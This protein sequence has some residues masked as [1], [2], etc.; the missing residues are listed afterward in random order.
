MTARTLI[1]A[2]ALTFFTF[3][4][5][6]AQEQEEPPAKQNAQIEVIL[7]MASNSGEGVDPKLE[8]YAETLERL[9][10]FSTYQQ[11]DRKVLSVNIPGGTTTNLFGGTK[12]K[13]GL[14][15]LE[16]DKLP[17]N[18]DWRRGDQKLLRTMIKLNDGTPAV[19]GGPQ[20]ED[21]TGTY[22]L[23]VKWRQ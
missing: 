3:I 6:H 10:R 13:L 5:A 18:L 4:C 11:K 1:L 15:P 16:D 21:N 17:A 23:I 12:L 22:L 8:P 9:F 14:K 20:A 7:V 19:V 2:L